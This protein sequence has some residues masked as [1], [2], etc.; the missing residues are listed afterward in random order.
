MASQGAVI[1]IGVLFSLL[2][3]D[4][5]KGA[6][7]ETLK[8]F[9]NFANKIENLKIDDI[10]QKQFNSALNSANNEFGKLNIG[11]ITDALIS[12]I[13]GTDDIKE[14]QKAITDFIDSI[15]LLKT[16]TSGY[17]TNIFKSINF[18]I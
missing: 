12:T 2:K 7:Q 6:T 11:K 14:Q 10:L 16:A 9:D 1:K 3:K 8:I 4:S 15:N 13:N 17:T 5:I 18:W